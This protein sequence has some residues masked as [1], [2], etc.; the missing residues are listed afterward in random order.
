MFMFISYFKIRNGVRRG[1]DG[2]RGIMIDG[3][4][5]LLLA[6]NLSAKER[7]VEKCR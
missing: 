6:D 5:K 4:N 7:D 1:E 2:K 3:I